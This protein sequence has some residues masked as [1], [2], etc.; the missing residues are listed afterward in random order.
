MLLACIFGAV[1]TAR[2]VMVV[3][4][5]FIIEQSLATAIAKLLFQT[6]LDLL[7]AILIMIALWRPVAAPNSQSAPLLERPAH[8]NG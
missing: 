8:V 7:P 5:L 3:F 2:G 6:L 4:L 1:F